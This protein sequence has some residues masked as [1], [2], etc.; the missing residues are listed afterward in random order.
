MNKN[1]ILLLGA[2]FFLNGCGFYPSLKLDCRDNKIPLMVN[3]YSNSKKFKET[4][5]FSSSIYPPSQTFESSVSGNYVQT[6]TTKYAGKT[7][8]DMS[9][10]LLS[11]TKGLNDRFIGGIVVSDEDNAEFK[12]YEPG[13]V[14]I[15]LNGKVIKAQG[16]K[17]E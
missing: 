17:N 8:S 14:S 4:S 1:I 5:E 6:T 2:T 10:D 12:M 11:V 7:C 9:D 15:S 3:S 16:G 13:D